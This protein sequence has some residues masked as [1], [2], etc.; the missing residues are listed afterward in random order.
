MIDIIL[1]II[2]FACLGGIIFII[3]RKLFFLSNLDLSKIPKEKIAK[4][5]RD[6]LE[7]KIAR[8]MTELKNKT[9]KILKTLISSFK[10]KLNKAL[11]YLKNTL[12]LIK[13]KYKLFR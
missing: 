12:K 4:M 5:K 7:K 10:S 2:F 11:I 6:L 8:E 13:K 1:L 9:I 3:S